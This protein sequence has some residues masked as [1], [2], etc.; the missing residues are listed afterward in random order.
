MP[1]VTVHLWLAERTLERWALSPGLSPFPLSDLRS[2]RAFQQGALGPDMGYFPGGLRYL[3]DLSHKVR[4]GALTRNLL[5][6]ARRPQELAFAWGWVTHVLADRLIHPVVARGVGE[7]LTGDRSRSISGEEDLPAHVRVETGMDAWI[8]ARN[9]HLAT[10]GAASLA[11]LFR[12]GDLA[13]LAR[14]Y[15]RTHGVSIPPETLGDS[16]IRMLRMGCHALKTI[17][18]L[19][20]GRDEVSGEAGAWCQAM[21][22]V[23]PW[24]GSRRWPG[25]LALSYLSPV[26][27]APWVQHELQT[28]AAEF[29]DRM[30]EVFR[31]PE[32]ALPNVNLDTGRPDPWPVGPGVLPPTAWN[33]RGTVPAPRSAVTEA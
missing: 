22:R 3:S 2:V 16:Y 10:A 1:N 19:G 27:P 29:P 25:V 17:S 31:D 13:F 21:G 11:P 9:P 23:L 7:L 5:A 28:V 4:S 26:D 12:Q 32:A 33:T 6:E 24:L 14:A 30:M 15:M 8:S 18:M 20:R